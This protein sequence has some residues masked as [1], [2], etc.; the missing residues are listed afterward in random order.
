[1]GKN[2]YMLCIDNGLSAG[3]VALVDPEG[4]IAG[5]SSFKNEILNDGRF[6][7]VDMELFYNKTA[8]T[9]RNLILKIGI[10]PADII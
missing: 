9:V 5:L 10:N 4:N 2:K 8:D 7:E 3:K 6:S 1:M